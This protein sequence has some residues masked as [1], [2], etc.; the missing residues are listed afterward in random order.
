M[1]MLKRPLPVILALMAIGVLLHFVFS[2]FYVE[3]VDIV[4][5]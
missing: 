3:L 4:T 5:V 2:P 1:E